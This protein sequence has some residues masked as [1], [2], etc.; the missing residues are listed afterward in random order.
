V[1]HNLKEAISQAQQSYESARRSARDSHNEWQAAQGR[2]FRLQ[3]QVNGSESIE[4]R[5]R[6]REELEQ[7]E[8][9]LV[10]WGRKT[11]EAKTAL[12]RAEFA[13]KDAES[14]LTDFDRELQRLEY[15]ARN[16]TPEIRIQ[17][18]N[19]D[20][21]QRTTRQEEKKLK[22]LIRE[23]ESIVARLATF[24]VEEQPH[25]AQAA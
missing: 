23:Q 19:V 17:A 25:H 12:T 3:A 1:R 7:A 4:E 13:V 10:A 18:Q 2:I 11:E 16:L 5:R 6:L 14:A 8:C 22:A 24:T 21:S 9:A 20:A 15:R